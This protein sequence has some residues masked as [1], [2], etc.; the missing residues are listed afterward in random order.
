M[1][2]DQDDQIPRRR[3]YEVQERAH[4]VVSE[5][6]SL[7]LDGGAPESFKSVLGRAVLDYRA[8]LRKH[9]SETAIKNEWEEVDEAIAP[10]REAVGRQ[11]AVEVE[12][13][14]RTRASQTQFRPAIQQLPF[15]Y[16]VQV[17][18]ELDDLAKNLGLSETVRDETPGDEADMSDL[19]HLLKS[20]GQ[21]EALRNLPGDAGE[22]EAEAEA[23]VAD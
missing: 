7:A 10:I 4:A 18:E 6:R 3:F 20:R 5:Y 16:L 19:R 9:R 8:A 21:K 11:V 23:E 17:I 14:G 15:Q 1:T 22:V 2:D 13:T 12:A